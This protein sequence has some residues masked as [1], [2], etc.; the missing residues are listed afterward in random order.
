MLLEAD[1]GNGNAL[2]ESVGESVHQSG[3]PATPGSFENQ[4]RMALAARR[5]A[6]RSPFH[7]PLHELNSSSMPESLVAA[8]VHDVVLV[9]LRPRLSMIDQIGGNQ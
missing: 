9:D 3:F 4:H 2:I 6:V 5:A 8:L 7:Q 1:P